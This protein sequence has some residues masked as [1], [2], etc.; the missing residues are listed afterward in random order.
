M[1]S[2]KHFEDFIRRGI[3]KKQSPDLSRSAFLIKNAEKD[4]QTLL[5]M[6]QKLGMSDLH[7]DTYIK[8]GY[9]ILMSYVRAKMFIDGYYA[10]GWGGHEAEVSYLRKLG[11]SENEI[12][13]ADQLRFF[14][15]G[16]MYYG[17]QLDVE[18]ALKVLE[19]IREIIPRLKKILENHA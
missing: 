1:S 14:R 16:I 12:Q 9:D 11:F 13:F 10:S 7:V 5:D 4:Y 2:L 8:N 19:F 6:I 18:Y 3:V 17:T 15:N